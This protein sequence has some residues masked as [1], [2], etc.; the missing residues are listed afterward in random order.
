[1]K[2]YTA[3]GIKKNT[4]KREFCVQVGKEEKVLSGMEIYIWTALLWTICE[5]EAIYGRV[6]QLLRI[7]FGEEEA[8]Q[9][10][11][12]EEYA[13]GFRR[14]C[15]RGLIVCCEGEDAE[16]AMMCL[17]RTAVLEPSRISLQERW[18]AFGE[19]LRCGRG[20]RFSLR[21]FQRVPLEEKELELLEKIRQ[22]G[23]MAYHLETVRSQAGR[24]CFL[25]ADDA[26]IEEFQETMQKEFLA[27]VIT[28]Y[29]KKFLNI[30]SVGKE[31]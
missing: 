23:D 16:E 25:P 17:M 27:D 3:I 1:M 19:S 10:I 13:F 11:C 24:T 4:G 18:E 15:I 30:Y 7:T 28:L 20:L 21:A 8:E 29:G 12:R 6:E 2:W 31:V 26:V 5:E 22:S 14:L 9:R